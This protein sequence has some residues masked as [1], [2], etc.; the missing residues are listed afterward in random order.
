MRLLRLIRTG[1]RAPTLQIFKGALLA[2]PVSSTLAIAWERV[3]TMGLAGIIAVTLFQ[4]FLSYAV[5]GWL[6]NRRT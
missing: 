4:L 2:L 3:A 5:S 6:Q 1:M